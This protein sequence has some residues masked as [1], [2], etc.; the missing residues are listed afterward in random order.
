MVQADAIVSEI[1]ALQREMSR[2]VIKAMD[3]V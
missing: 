3:N 1:S 2:F